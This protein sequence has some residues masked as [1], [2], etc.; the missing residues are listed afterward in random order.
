MVKVNNKKICASC[1]ISNTVYEYDVKFSDD[2]YAKK[3]FSIK[4]AES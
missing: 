4:T 1:A 3:P 2:G